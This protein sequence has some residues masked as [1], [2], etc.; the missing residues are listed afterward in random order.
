MLVQV[1]GEE[2]HGLLAPS[3][4]RGRQHEDKPDGYQRPDSPASI[5]QCHHGGAKSAGPLI[6]VEWAATSKPV[7]GWLDSARPDAEMAKL[8]TRTRVT[9]TREAQ[10]NGVASSS[11]V[12]LA[13]AAGQ[14]HGDLRGIVCISSIDWDFIWQ[15]HQEIM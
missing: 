13:E 6:A 7:R 2:P 12:P 4:S 5:C 15:G 8:P 10:S 1:L 11:T 14:T 3:Y 9:L